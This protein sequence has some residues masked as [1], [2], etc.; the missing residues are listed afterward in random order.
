VN[1]EP[2]TTIEEVGFSQTLPRTGLVTVSFLEAAF[3]LIGAG[4]IA[5]ILVRRR[6]A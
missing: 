4:G 1:I 6:E 2:V 3:L 5:L